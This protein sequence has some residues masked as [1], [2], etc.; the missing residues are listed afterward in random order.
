MGPPGPGSDKE[1][2]VKIVDN[3][4]QGRERSYTDVTLAYP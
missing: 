3:S 4:L 1:E 2:L